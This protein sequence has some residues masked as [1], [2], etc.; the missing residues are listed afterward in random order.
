MSQADAEA[1]AAPSWGDEVS[2]MLV[3]LLCSS[4]RKYLGTPLTEV[5]EEERALVCGGAVAGAVAG[6]RVG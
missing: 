6:V 1:D 2:S 4:H 3:G 5:E